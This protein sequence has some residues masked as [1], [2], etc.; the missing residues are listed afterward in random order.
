MRRM[1]WVYFGLLLMTGALADVRLPAMFSDGMV[2]QRGIAIPVWGWAATGEQVTVTLEGQTVTAAADDSGTWKVALKPMKEG[3]PYQ[4]TVTAKNT[5]TVK[6]VL[7]GDVWLCSGQSNM[8]MGLYGAT[9][10][11]QEC[12]TANYPNIRVFTV[13]RCGEI[14]PQA[15]CTGRWQSVTP[16]TAAGCYATAYF[17]AKELQ[18]H[19]GVP[20]GLLQ[21]AWSGSVAEGW[22][23]RT[24]LEANPELRP[25][26]Q[27][28]DNTFASFTKDYLEKYGPAIRDWMTTAE[29]AKAEGKP[30]PIPPTRT[31]PQ[32]PRLRG[33]A[34]YMAT[35]MYNGQLMPLVPYA[36]KGAIWYQGESNSGR[37]MEYA[38]LF[39]AMIRNWRET[40]GQGDFPFLFVQLP[41][42]MARNPK[43]EDGGW[44]L[45][46]ECQQAAL[47]LPNT[48]MAVTIDIGEAASIHPL[49]KQD[50]GKRLALVALGT[51]YEKKI[52]Y[53]GPTY[54]GMTIEGD[55]ARITFTH[56]GG[57][58]V[59]KDGP[60]K[61]FSVCGED[62][63]FVWADAAIIGDSVVVSSPLVTKPIAVRY[64]WANNPEC[65]LYNKA[66][67]PA[68]PFRTDA[69]K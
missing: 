58:L 39:P 23:S 50:V 45:M 54:A 11:M 14:T 56:L 7:L 6:D 2:L 64:A 47:A 57:G 15:E 17:F 60:L 66:G 62:K 21:C 44:A 10:G 38:K 22:M 5:L 65:N 68:G 31:I 55:K 49:N 3:G 42:Y 36:L 9:G 46:R 29:R 63:Q 34:A 51:V 8:E 37:Q 59:A 61:G 4:L 53:M 20:I 40:W 16:Q 41:N 33:E 18:S 27:K 25:L 28:T 26:M 12:K 52:D 1:L 48:G 19:V 24:A 30:L 13:G 32:D 69:P 43:P 35:M 67:L